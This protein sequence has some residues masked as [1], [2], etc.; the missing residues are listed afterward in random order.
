MFFSILLLISIGIG[1]LTNINNAKAL[2]GEVLYED[3]NWFFNGNTSGTKMGSAV[4]GVGDVNGDGNPDVLVGAELYQSA[5]DKE[6]AAFLFL[7]S[8]GGL[9][10]VPDWS[11]FGGQQGSHL[12]CVLTGIGD[13]NKDG[14]EDIAI[15]ACE[16]N[17]EVDGEVNKSKVGAVYVFHGSPSFILSTQP[18]WTFIGD[19][20]EAYVGSAL[21]SA[22]DINHDGYSDLLI[23][24]P[25]YDTLDELGDPIL[26][27][28]GKVYLFFGSADGLSQV[29]NWTAE[30]IYNAEKFGSAVTSADI[31]NDGDSDVIIGAPRPTNKGSV[32]VYKN[33]DGVLSS[34]PKILLH[35][36]TEAQF[37]AKLTGVGDVNKDGFEDVVIG[38]PNFKELIDLNVVSVGCVYFYSGSPTGLP[39]TPDKEICGTFPNGKL[40]ASIAAAGDMDG[41]GFDDFLVGAPDF[42]DIND[43]SGEEQQG[44]VFLFF[45]TAK[46]SNPPNVRSD[47]DSAFGGKADTD[48]GIAISSIGDVNGDNRLDIIVGAPDYKVGGIRPGRAMAYFAGIPGIP[49]YEIFP[50][51]LPLVTTGN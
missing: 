47:V 25:G 13:L 43:D 48:F 46:D 44:A 15:S 36:Q 28:N 4:S 37:G 6:G 51:Y 16:H 33:N 22:G 12:G 20:V 29:P 49:D 45:G 38:A 9:P 23:S 10:G 34:T 42:S 50:V 26:T 2:I 35:N 27:N 1:L 24:A 19:Q 40:G 11:F 31:D 3:P 14:S 5:I 30:G 17:I 8:G 18:D 39:D 7:S 32:Y 41:D 21:S